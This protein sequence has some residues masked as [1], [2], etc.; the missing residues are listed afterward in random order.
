MDWNLIIPIVLGAVIALM[1]W[2]GR[3]Q[4]ERIDAIE[5]DIRDIKTSLGQLSTDHERDHRWVAEHEHIL[6]G[7]KEDMAEVK[8]K[9]GLIYET[10]VIRQKNGNGGRS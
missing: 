2:I 4:V 6:D 3:R 5:R 9:V 1:G 8:T 10:I 7:L